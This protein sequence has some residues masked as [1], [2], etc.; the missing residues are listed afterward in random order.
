MLKNKFVNILG[1]LYTIEY[2]N[3]NEEPDFEEKGICGYCSSVMPNIVVGNLATF[4]QFE[5]ANH[6]E[7][8]KE[9]DATLR[10]EIIHA[11]FNESGLKDSSFISEIPWARN[12]E[13][14]DWF[15]IQSPKIYKVFKELD[16]L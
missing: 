9:M 3:Y 13:M 11:F 6:K 7:I 16:I 14:V 8:K 10:H 12:E 2:R 15:A 5:D 1:T 4:P